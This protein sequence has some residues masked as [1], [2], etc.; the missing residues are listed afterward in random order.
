[1]TNH[2]HVAVL[3]DALFAH[4]GTKELFLEVAKFDRISCGNPVISVRRDTTMRTIN[5]GS[6]ML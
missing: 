6:V 3:E 1:M 5:N 4:L 2:K